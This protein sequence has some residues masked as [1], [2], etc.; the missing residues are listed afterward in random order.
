MK[1]IEVGDWGDALSVALV[2]NAPAYQP[3]SYAGFWIWPLVETDSDGEMRASGILGVKA[4][5][6]TPSAQ[7]R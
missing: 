3:L 7:S 6:E 1:M 4:R 5:T 2:R